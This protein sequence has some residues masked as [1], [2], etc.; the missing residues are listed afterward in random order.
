MHT[1]AYSKHK[2]F[3]T[4]GVPEILLRFLSAI[5]WNI[6]LDLGC[7]DGQ[8]LYALQR[9]GCRIEWRRISLILFEGS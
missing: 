7:G 5:P 2:Q 1:D 4:E 3:Y 6:V 8:F 9:R